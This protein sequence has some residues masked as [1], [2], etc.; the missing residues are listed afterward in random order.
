VTNVINP[1][2]EKKRP[3]LDMGA[4]ST[5]LKKMIAGCWNEDAKDRP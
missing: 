1:L 5:E 3:F 4:I 2:M